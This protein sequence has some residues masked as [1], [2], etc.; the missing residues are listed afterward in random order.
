[1]DK[2]IIGGAPVIGELKDLNVYKKYF[3][4][5]YGIKKADGKFVEEKVDT[6]NVTVNGNERTLLKTI[7]HAHAYD[8]VEPTDKFGFKTFADGGTIGMG[9]SGVVDERTENSKD[10]FSITQTGGKSFSVEDVGT[11][12]VVFCLI[13]GYM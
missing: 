8:Y 12:N 2:K 7:K 1:M 5:V 10:S 9:A 3:Y 11:E 4:D 13:I 6:E